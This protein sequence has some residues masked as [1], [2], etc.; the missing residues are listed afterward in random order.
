MAINTAVSVVTDEFLD[1]RFR[2]GRGWGDQFNRLFYPI[3]SAGG[4]KVSIV[5]FQAIDSGSIPG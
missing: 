5:A 4:V 3:P 1:N 2:A